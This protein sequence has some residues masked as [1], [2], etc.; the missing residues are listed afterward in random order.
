[1][2][3][4][5]ADAKKGDIIQC[6]TISGGIEIKSNEVTLANAPP[7]IRNVKFLPEASAAGWSLS[8]DVTGVDPDG[9][10]VTYLYEWTK[11]GEPAGRTNKMEGFMKTGDKISVKI[12]PY[13]VE[14]YGLA[15]VYERGV[16]NMSPVI[17]QDY[18]YHFDGKTWTYQVRAS[19]PDGD[20]ITYSLVSPPP[21]M[22]VDAAGGLITWKVPAGFKGQ[23]SV[24]LVVSDNRGGKATW[25]MNI[26]INR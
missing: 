23:A 5:C 1:M 24:T 4:N 18:T 12:T 19:D 21:G 7:D 13:D 20:P 14:D 8:V 22:T 11:N 25:P 16:G 6:R 9:D 26:K 2:V 3:F 17:T 15:R 10:A